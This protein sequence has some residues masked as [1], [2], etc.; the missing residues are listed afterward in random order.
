MADTYKPGD[1]VP[2]DGRVKCTQEQ[3]RR[4]QRQKGHE[5]P[6]LRPLGSAQRQGL[7]LAVCLAETLR[8]VAEYYAGDEDMAM[9]EFN[10]RPLRPGQSLGD[11]FMDAFREHVE[12][13]TTD[14][15]AELEALRCPE[16]PECRLTV[17]PTADGFEL[18][19]ESCEE[20]RQLVEH[21]MSEL[22]AEPT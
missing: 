19:G 8:P 3:R 18:K 5:V 10:G 15:A 17:Q 14:F 12:N 6:A 2:K 13:V 16:H 1:T 21:R 9:L 11:A 7:Y 4:R 22:G 20:F